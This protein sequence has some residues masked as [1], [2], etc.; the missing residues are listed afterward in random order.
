M[1]LSARSEA[2]KRLKTAKNSEAWTCHLEPLLLNEA[3]IRSIDPETANESQKEDWSQILFTGDF[4][5][6]NFIPFVLMYVAMSKIILAPLLA[7]TMPFMTIILPFLALKFMYRLP[8]TWNQYWE[9]M[10]PMLFGSPVAAGAGAAAAP[11]IG[12]I[13][14]W[15]SMIVSYAHGMYLPYTNAV[16]CYKIDQL[17]IKGSA[18]IIDTIRRL[19]EVADVWVSYGLKKPWSL[20][21]PAAYGDDRQ[22]LAYIVDDKHLL[23]EIYR[24]IGRVE[25]TAAIQRDQGLV[26]VEWAQSATPFC[27]MVDGVDALLPQGRRVPFTLVMGPSEHHVICTGPNRGGKST[28]LRT[29]LTNL[30][31]AQTWGVAFAA[32]CVLTPVEW[33]ISS[34]RLEDRP[35]QE[36]LFER[37]VSVAGEILKRVRL[38]DTRGWVII[39]ELFHTTNPPDAATASQIFLHQLWNSDRA[40]SIV[41]THLFVHAA[42]APTNVQR[43]CVESEFVE[44]TGKINYKYLVAKGINTMSSVEELLLESKVIGA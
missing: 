30:I 10:K 18:A 15:G 2:W 36:S 28:F 41:S 6:L 11:S 38:G 17:M 20:P 19:R 33:I 34:L 39:D 4:A 3:A 25:I 7:W 13:L 16:H 43:L 5:S 27:K 9:T 44:E 24:A 29:V 40:T 23:P 31:F 32:R 26:P 42:T 22:V 37:E 14:Q 12:T 1:I 21:D 35:G 8:I